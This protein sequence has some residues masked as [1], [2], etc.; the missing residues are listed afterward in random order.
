MLN[1]MLNIVNSNFDLLLQNLRCVKKDVFINLINIFLTILFLIVQLLKNVYTH[2]TINKI[3]N[4]QYIK[5]LHLFKLK[6]N[7]L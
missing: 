2:V 1:I 6:M 3:S 4:E 7:M 5:F